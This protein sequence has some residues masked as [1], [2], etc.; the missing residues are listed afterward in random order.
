MA[1]NRLGRVLRYMADAWR[2]AQDSGDAVK[3]GGQRMFADVI[4]EMG[5]LGAYGAGDVVDTEAAY[6]LA[7]TAYAVYSAIKLV[8]DR[9]A[10][11]RAAFEVKRRMGVDLEDLGNHAFERLLARPNTLMSGSFLKRYTSWWYLLR[12]NAYVFVASAAPGVGEPSELWP[13]VASAVTPRPDLM[14]EGRGVFRG[15]LVIDYE[16]QVNGRIDILPGENVVH[17]RTPNPFSF[18]EG[19]SPLT[20]AL[21]PLQ[22]DAAQALWVRD[23]FGAK[24]AI[25]TA[26][27]SVP[28]ET[29]DE[30]FDDIKRRLREQ[31]D[32]GQRT[33][34]TRA[35]DL[36][37][38]VIQQTIEQMQ[39]LSGREF[40]AKA[41]D[42]IYGIPEGLITGG[43]SGD[44]R[45]AAEIAL[46]RNTV[47][48][49][50]DYFAEEWS[51][52]IGPFYGRD[53]VIEAP[54]IV[55]QDRALEAQE[56][57]V[58]SQDQTINENRATRG[59]KASSHPWAEV[60]VRL[61]DIAGAAGSPTSATEPAGMVGQ[62]APAQVMAQAAGR[63]VDVDVLEGM[64]PAAQAAL[65]KAAARVVARGA[66]VE[67]AGD[68]TAEWWLDTTLA[69]ARQNGKLHD[70]LG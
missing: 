7:V 21:T 51:A 6:T 32:K 52:N 62:P 11:R 19:L 34:I 2:Y 16:Y 39:V 65:L 25:P 15:Q 69:H 1:T 49:L 24:N 45:L 56:Y 26:I 58:Y 43:L 14:H 40:N 37:V 9:A 3:A 5:R 55:P 28:A 35:G 38:A 20:A 33:L 23:F 42:R 12:G 64:T 10:D 67:T 44:S 29:D 59:L 61:L 54:N 4:T 41:V 70:D 31:F 22:T 48:P 36:S 30:D 68:G 50:L 18:W 53:V 17:F 66:P 47:Q 63:A 57:Q 46:A 60:P 27:I 8:S 13:L